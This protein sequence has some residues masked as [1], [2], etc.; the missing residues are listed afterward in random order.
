MNFRT[1]FFD[2]VFLHWASRFFLKT[3]EKQRDRSFLNE[4]KRKKIPV[5]IRT[6]RNRN[7]RQRR[8]FLTEKRK[9]K[10]FFIDEEKEEVKKKK[11]KTKKFEPGV[12]DEFEMIIAP[13]VDVT[14]FNLVSLLELRKAIRGLFDPGILIVVRC[15]II[16]L[17]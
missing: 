5:E 12:T 14:S 11:R 3:T 9:K 2:D 1:E 13:S 4:I 17:P 15:K 6:K 16:S 10:E 8:D 7:K